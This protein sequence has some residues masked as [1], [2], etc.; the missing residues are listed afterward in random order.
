M[1]R[2][3]EK[4]RPDTRPIPKFFFKDGKISKLK[5]AAF[6]KTKEGSLAFCDY[7]IA[8][9]GAKKEAIRTKKSID[10]RSKLIRKKEKMQAKLEQVNKELAE[11]GEQ[12]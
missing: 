11:L 4:T 9:W 1:V 7:M 6:P 2:L 3:K 10:P 8:K 12:S 5:K